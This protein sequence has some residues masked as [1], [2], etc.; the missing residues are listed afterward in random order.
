MAF[1][2]DTDV[3]SAM[4]RS[5]RIDPALVEW[6]RSLSPQALFLSVMTI[7]EIERGIAKQRMANPEFATDLQ[8]WLDHLLG[9]YQDRILP[10][11]AS[12]AR[13]WGAL[14]QQVGNANI[15]ILIAAT[16]IEHGLTVATFNGPHFTPTGVEVYNPLN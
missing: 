11:T 13:R 16:A 1:L 2:L 4:R 14:S 15:D 8:Q 7:G 10:V 6:M 9:H 5:D 12:I 3:L